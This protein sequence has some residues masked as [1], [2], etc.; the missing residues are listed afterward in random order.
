MKNDA[1][2][3]PGKSKILSNIL[4]FVGKYLYAIRF[5]IKIEVPPNLKP[6]GPVLVLSKHCS[7]HDMVVGLPAMADHLHRK[8]AWCII[9]DS[10]TKPYFLGFFLKIGGIPIDRKNPDKSKEQL[11]FARKTLYDG[12]V[13][14]LFPE[15]SRH[16]GK[17]GKGKS[18]GFRFI[19][20]KPAEPI[21]V[22]CVGLEYE[23]GFPRR[24]L[25]IRF[26]SPRSYSK[27]DDAEVFLHECMLEIAKLSNL[28]YKFPL[29]EPKRKTV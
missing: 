27:K 24:K 21:Q 2:I 29:P 8:D 26:G 1:P 9:K 14:V 16:R 7:N 20:G 23:D 12:N 10:L 17:M 3:H 6:E 11:L 18:P 13:L 15:Q 5:K 4:S 28:V 19:A 25:T 22:I